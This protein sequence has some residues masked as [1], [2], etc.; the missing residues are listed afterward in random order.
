VAD[1]VS[2]DFTELDQLSADLGKVAEHVGPN[3]NTAITVTSINIKK[4]WQEPLRGS[5]TLPQLPYA[6]NFDITTFQGFGASVI[7]SEIGFDKEKPQGAL[8]NVSEY[9]TPSITGRGY[10]IAALH[11]NESDFQKGLEI[12]VEK[13]EKAVGL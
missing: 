7:K 3:V 8:G 5:G 10:G 4:S 2:F 11:A 13:A 1:D 6:I 12:A 9:G